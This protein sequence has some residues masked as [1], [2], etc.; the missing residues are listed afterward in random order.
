MKTIVRGSV[1][2]ERGFKKLKRMFDY[3]YKM[4]A[5]ILRKDKH[6]Q[7]KLIHTNHKTVEKYR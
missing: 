1:T 6:L 3:L 7:F 4:C 5:L 2:L